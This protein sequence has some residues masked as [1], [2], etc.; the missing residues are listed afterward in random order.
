[1]T[2]TGLPDVL[3]QIAEGAVQR[4]IDNIN[5]FEQVKLLAD[6]GCGKLRLPVELGGGGLST[7]EFFSAIIDLGA[8]DP[9]VA[10]IFR[11]HF[12]FTEEFLALGTATTDRFLGLVAAGKIFGGAHSERGT[13]AVGGPVFDTTLV[14]DGDRFV[15]NGEKF[16]TTGTLFADYVNVTA[17]KGTEHASVIIPTDRDGVEI[18]DDWDGFGQ[19]RTGS[20]TTRFTNVTVHDDEILRA[21]TP[22]EPARPSTQAPFFQLYLHAVIAGILRSVV[23][24]AK[25]LVL[26]RSRNFSH[27]S[28]GVAA[29]D[30][31]LQQIVGE[32]ASLAFVAEATV[33]I[34]AESI[35]AAN[36]SVREGIPDA[37]LAHEAALSTSKA[38]FVLDELGTRAATLLFEAGGASASSG[39]KD[40]D[41]H[42][43]SIRTIT[44]H[45]PARLKAQAVG[46][47]VL[48]GE[49][50]PGNGYF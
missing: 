47:N 28:S 10:H 49:Q 2:Q 11:A 24:D 35:G 21:V 34:A 43:R 50:L 39:A 44:L 3:N 20:G 25:A 4:E 30:P 45:N 41:R 19:R 46:A 1:M 5:P 14:A 16:Y 6:A 29:A 26:G 37:A 7:R 32:L 38:K 48:L 22:G 13:N 15:L 18:L 42:W 40:L 31:S 12:G 36:D 17:A 9:T 27:A 23:A 8:A 33:L